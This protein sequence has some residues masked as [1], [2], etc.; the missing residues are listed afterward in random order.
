VK[1]EGTDKTVDDEIQDY[2]TVNE[3]VLDVIGNVRSVVE[4]IM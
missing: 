2:L 1:F 3:L 4:T